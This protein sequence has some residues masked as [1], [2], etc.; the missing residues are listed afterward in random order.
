[1]VSLYSTDLHMVVICLDA[2]QCNR[3]GS[4]EEDCR[5]GNIYL[6]YIYLLYVCTILLQHCPVSILYVLFF[7]LLFC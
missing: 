3:E 7:F 2:Q 4:E 1:M 6:L 5:L